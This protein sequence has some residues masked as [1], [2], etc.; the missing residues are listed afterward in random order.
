MTG[1]DLVHAMHNDHE[2]VEMAFMLISSETR[3]GRRAVAILPKPFKLAELR[4]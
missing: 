2:L 3:F 1:T 4:K